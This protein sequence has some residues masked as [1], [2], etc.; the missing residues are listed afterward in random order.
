MQTQNDK[1][2]LWIIRRLIFDTPI[3]FLQQFVQ[4][5]TNISPTDSLYNVRK[6][7]TQIRWQLIPITIGGRQVEEYELCCI[8]SILSKQSNQCRDCNS[9]SFFLVASN[10]EEVTP[11]LAA[12]TCRGRRPNRD[13][14]TKPC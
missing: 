5:F 4:H 12:K 2:D 10:N 13:R 3:C 14:F 1:E 7:L 11:T 6:Y 9:Y 8:W